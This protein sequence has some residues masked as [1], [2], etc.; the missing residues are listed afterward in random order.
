MTHER[1]LVLG[2]AGFIGSHI[3]EALIDH[4]YPVRVFDL[5]RRTLANLA[6]LIDRIEIVEGDF[7][8]VLDVRNALVDVDYVFHLVSTT[9]PQTA[10]DNPIYDAESNLIATLQ[11]LNEA[12]SADVKKAIFISSGGT[13]YGVADTT[14]IVETHPT[15]PITAHGIIKLAIE[16][17]LHLYH[18]LYG[19]DYVVLRV[20]NPYG[21]RQQS[22]GAQQGVVSVFID[23]M[24]RGEPINIWGDGSVVRDFVYIQDVAQA[25]VLAL[26]SASPHRIFNVGSG[27]GLSLNELLAL[28]EKVTGITPHVNYLPGRSTDVPR[29]ILDTT[30]IRA[31]WG[32]SATTP[33]QVGLART[34]EWVQHQDIKP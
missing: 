19:L 11:L 24:R 20:S 3:V 34:W 29:N 14:P 30:R 32:W 21:E 1:C 18:H 7:T 8:N 12:R 16:K 9:L 22:V 26:T 5:P 2:G 31:E 6:H 27:V 13:V 28:L 10:N 23:R 25:F 33:L 17:Y 4:D 15:M